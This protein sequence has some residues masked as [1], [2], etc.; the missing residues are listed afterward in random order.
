MKDLRIPLRRVSVNDVEVTT[1]IVVRTPEHDKLKAIQDITNAVG[2]FLEHT[3]YTLCER[4]PHGNFW[5]VAK[6]TTTIL[7]EHFG[8]NR[9]QL[10]SEKVAILQGLRAAHEENCR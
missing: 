5:P 10:E 6:S 9:D 1:S 8:I 3:E 7:A 4:D 2:Q